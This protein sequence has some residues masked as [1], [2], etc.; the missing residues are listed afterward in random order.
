M[1]NGG[2]NPGWLRGNADFI[3]FELEQGFLFVDRRNA[4]KYL[5]E[6]VSKDTLPPLTSRDR[7]QLNRAYTRMHKGALRG[8][9]V[10]L[11]EISKL[12][13]LEGSFVIHSSELDSDASLKA[14]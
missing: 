6:I 13:A 9:V 10:Y 14:K 1:A 5:E 3:A 4:L 12:Q 2:A 11:V 8:D 7:P